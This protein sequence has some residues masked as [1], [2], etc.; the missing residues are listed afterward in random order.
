[1]APTGGFIVG[2]MTQ[3]IGFALQGQEPE[4]DPQK[5][6]ESLGVMLHACDPN[7]REAE[8]GHF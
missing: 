5:T 1:M 3:M 2:E 8:T 7:A 4:F 6:L